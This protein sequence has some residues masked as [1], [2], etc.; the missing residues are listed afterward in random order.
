MKCYAIVPAANAAKFPSAH[1]ITLTSGSVLLVQN[2]D[3]SLFS[4]AVEKSSG[5]L[6][7]MF[8]D[9]TALTTSQISALAPISLSAGATVLQLA[10]AAAAINPLMSL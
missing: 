7:P 10:A 4:D 1:W 6:L 8:Y 2:A 5:T 9:S 3:Y